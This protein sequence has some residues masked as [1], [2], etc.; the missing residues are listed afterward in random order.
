M[1]EV[2]LLDQLL[3]LAPDR[4]VHPLVP[5]RLLH[6]HEVVL[7]RAQ[8]RPRP[9]DSNPPDEIR[10]REVVVLHRIQRYQGA[11]SPKASLTVYCDCSLLGLR[12]F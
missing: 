1:D 12:D 7:L 9:G 5:H 2:F 3:Y 6:L 8:N 4:T 11:R 10:R